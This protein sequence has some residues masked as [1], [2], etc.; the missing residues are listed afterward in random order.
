MSSITV[1]V[2]VC[3]WVFLYVCVCVLFDST[4]Q[5][6]GCQGNGNA[7]AQRSLR[8]ATSCADYNE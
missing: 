8:P 1:Y 4:A 2:C 7:A 6:F 3:V 5:M